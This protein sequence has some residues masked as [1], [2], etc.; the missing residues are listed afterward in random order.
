LIAAMTGLDTNVLVRYIVRDDAAQTK[1]ADGLMRGLTPEKP[2]FISMVALAELIWVLNS[3]YRM[4]KAELIHCIERLLNAQ[5]LV[6]EGAAAV[7]M[8]AER[9]ARAKCDFA[10]CLIERSGFIAGCRRTVTFDA[11]AA[12]S[13][14]MTLL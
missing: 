13:A 2:A 6:T 9:F 12:G 3:Y 5:N 14:G 4:P 8:A 1:R 10:D 7:R 11:N